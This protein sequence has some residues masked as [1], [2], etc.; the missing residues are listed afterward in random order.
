MTNIIQNNWTF[1]L[2]EIFLKQIWYIVSFPETGLFTSLQIVLNSKTAWKM[3]QK[4]S[5]RTNCFGAINKG[6]SQS[7]ERITLASHGMSSVGGGW[8]L[9]IDDNAIL[10]KLIAIT[11]TDG[12]FP[13]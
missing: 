11:L 1:C 6:I 4:N 3:E 2:C 9:F 13:N 7:D 10:T 5:T 12:I 8:A